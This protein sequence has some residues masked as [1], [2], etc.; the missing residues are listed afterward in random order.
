ML[1]DTSFLKTMLLIGV[2]AKS[3]LTGVVLFAL[4]LLLT[5]QGYAKE[6]IGQITMLYAASV[7]F[8]S[9][10]V[11]QYAD[12]T[13]E[14]GKVLFYGGILTAVGLGTISLVG[15]PSI[16]NW[17]SNTVPATLIILVGVIMI[18]LAHGLINAPVVTHVAETKLA[19]R[20]GAGNVAA[21]Y[22]LVERFGHMLGPVIMG[23]MFLYFGLSWAAVGFVGLGVFVLAVLFPNPVAQ[24][25]SSKSNQSVS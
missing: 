21:T 6:D 19:A 12:R 24:V 22:R 10:A 14:T 5:N 20:L 25:E 2:P 13:G 9:T 16:I 15:L 1:K 8:A 18:G 17:N 7:I 23:Q 3:V 11:A 4:P